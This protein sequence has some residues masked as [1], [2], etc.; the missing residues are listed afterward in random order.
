MSPRLSTRLIIALVLTVSG[1][2]RS[3][4][5]MDD[6][7]TPASLDPDLQLSPSDYL[8]S[9][10]RPMAPQHW[11][12]AVVGDIMTS[13]YQPG[14]DRVQ[15]EQSGSPAEGIER[16]LE[17]VAPVLGGADLTFGNL[18]F[19]VLAAAPPSGTVPFNGHPSYLD[20]LKKVGFDVLFTA[21]NHALDQHVAGMESTLQ[22]LQSRNLVTL[23]TT[24]AGMPRKERLLVD[25]GGEEHLRIGFLNYTTNISDL[26]I[27]YDLEHLLLGRNINYAL[28]TKDENFRKDLLK[29]VASILFPSALIPNRDRFLENVQGN[30]A[31][32]R[33][34]GAEYVIVF[35]H[36]GVP[37]KAIPLADQ[38]E[39]ARAICARGADAVI[40]SGPHVLQPIELIDQPPEGGGAADPARECFIAYS[41]G[42][43]ISGMGGIP[44]YGMI[45]QMT[46]GR[47]GDHVYVQ[48]YKPQITHMTRQ[49]GP[50]GADDPSGATER[51]ELRDSSVDE[52]LAAV[53]KA[54]N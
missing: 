12:F 37:Q 38:K 14:S 7:Q 13:I 17:N 51:L 25:V 40:G 32:A 48:D 23:G 50:A 18:E 6:P 54:P 27:R 4:A 10:P 28:F 43:F 20:A 15:G 1:G 45:L 41:L 39:L 46:V 8:M 35:L 16:L 30:I 22:E 11:S 26:G 52:F 36:W 33:K 2:S 34:E 53:H 49:G 19:P 21:N 5:D 31:A 3:D 47:G 44:E 42:N 29:V 9:A 24:P